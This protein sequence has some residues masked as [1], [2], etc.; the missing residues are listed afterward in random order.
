MLLL[1]IMMLKPPTVASII[2]LHVSLPAHILNT[3]MTKLT[4]IFPPVYE[5]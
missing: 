1:L 3:S 4:Y 5:I 2:L